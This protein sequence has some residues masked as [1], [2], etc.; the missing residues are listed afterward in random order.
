M[1]DLRKALTDFCIKVGILK[2]ADQE[3]QEEMISYEIVYEPDTKDAH[4]QWMSE[5]TLRKGCENFNKNLAAGVVK[6]N[7]FHMQETDKFSIEKTWINEE[8]D[9]KVIG[10]DEPIK[11]GAWVAKIQYNDPELWALRKAGIVQGVSF[12][13]AGNVNEETAEITNLTFDGED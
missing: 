11:R 3:V 9:V 8:L 7:L 5:E 10:T 4:G 12:G 6:P 1:S 2:G 13:G